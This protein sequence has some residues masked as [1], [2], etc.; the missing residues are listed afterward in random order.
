MISDVKP[1]EKP[2]LAHRDSIS[3]RGQ[4]NCPKLLN[5]VSVYL[6]LGPNQLEVA[7][8]TSKLQPKTEDVRK[9]WNVRQNRRASPLLLVITYKAGDEAKASVCGP[10]GEN[11]AVRHSLDLSQVERLADAAL[12]EPNRNAASRF[13]MAMLPETASDLP[14]LRNS[15]LLAMQELHSGVPLRADWLQACKESQKLLRA[16]AYTIRA[17]VRT[18]W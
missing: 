14:G 11:P 5:P 4:D 9:L 8:A 17:D 16:R 2:F 10:V 7:L 12:A 3:W 15:G 18:W 6:G 13:L 1:D